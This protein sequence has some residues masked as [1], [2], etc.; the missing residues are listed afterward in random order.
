M[1]DDVLRDIARRSATNN[2][3]PAP[4]PE[5]L[6]EVWPAMVGTSIAKLTEP[7]G[8]EDATL[9]VAVRNQ[10]M[11]REWNRS[12]VLL[13]RRV[14]RFSPWPIET[15]KLTHDPTAGIHRDEP[16]QSGA[17]DEPPC[18]EPD[19]EEPPGISE[20]DGELQALIRSIDRQRRRRDG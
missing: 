17:A 19:G 3:L 1:W 8:L 7:L 11:V 4:R 9:S 10:K 14:R 2:A 5:L 18:E 16:S 20:L 13:L 6:C 12:P 15:L